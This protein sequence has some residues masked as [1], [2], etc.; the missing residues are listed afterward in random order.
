MLI[1]VI[2]SLASSSIC[3]GNR[4]NDLQS[5]KR[6]VLSSEPVATTVDSSLKATVLI[7]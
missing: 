4:E 5:H 3:R 6:T 1:E 2:E 7:F